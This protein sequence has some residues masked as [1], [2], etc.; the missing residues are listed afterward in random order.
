MTVTLTNPGFP[1]SRQ[2]VFRGLK[3]AANAEW[4]DKD[5]QPAEGGDENKTDEEPDAHPPEVTPIPEEEE[6]DPFDDFDDEDFDDE[7]DD[8][9]E[10]ELE[11]DYEIEPDDSDMFPDQQSDDDLMSNS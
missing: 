4:E 3:P 10:E 11:D 9:F 7:F 2:V 1:T 8:D 5:G 6:D